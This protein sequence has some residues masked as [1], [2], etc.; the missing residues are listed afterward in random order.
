MQ[1]LLVCFAMVTVFSE[2]LLCEF[3]GYRKVQLKI[4][5]FWNT[6]LG[7]WAIRSFSF[8]AA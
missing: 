2:L 6:V 4:P 5:F 7:H 8:E 1:M 3:S